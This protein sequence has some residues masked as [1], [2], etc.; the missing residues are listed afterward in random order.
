L[1]DLLLLLLP[2]TEAWDCNIYCCQQKLCR[3]EAPRYP[4]KYGEQQ[5]QQVASLLLLPEQ[6]A[7]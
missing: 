1:Q 7:R 3:L 6:M 4:W 2:V 5:Q